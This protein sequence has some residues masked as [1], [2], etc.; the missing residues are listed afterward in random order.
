MHNLAPIADRYGE[1]KDQIAALEDLLKPLKKELAESGYETIIGE[2]YT[3]TIQL[4]TQTEL[5]EERVIEKFRMTLDA[6]KKIVD[7]C[8]VEKAPSTKV[9][10]KPT[11]K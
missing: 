3:I 2:T 4:A 7:E 1:I 9:T 5:S 11:K 10:Y 8:K 6:Y